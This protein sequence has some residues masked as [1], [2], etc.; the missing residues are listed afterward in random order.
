MKKIIALA[1]VGFIFIGLGFFQVS[2]ENNPKQGEVKATSNFS[3]S[4]TIGTYLTLSIPTGSTVAFGNLTPGTPIEAPATGTIASVTTNAANG[5]TLGLSDAIAASNSCLVHTDTTT[6]IADYAG[7][8]ATPTIWTGGA[9]GLGATLFAA[10]TTKEVAWGTGTTYNDALNK[11]AGIPQTAATAHTAAG[12]KSGADTSTWAF[13][14]DVPNTQKTGS[15][16]G[17]A[18][19]TATAVLS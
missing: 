13:K 15:Y 8:I 17:S 18:T 9:T 6:Y 16:S 11:Y 12:F 7:T 14:I 19:F 5:Y 4:T 10:D 3:F 2:K 1:A